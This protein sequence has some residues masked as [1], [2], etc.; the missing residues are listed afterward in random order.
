MFDVTPYAHACMRF[1][2]GHPDVQDFGR[3]FKVAFQGAVS[4]RAVWCRCTIL[5]LSPLVPDA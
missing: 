3:K 5:A 1:L 2:L 4:T